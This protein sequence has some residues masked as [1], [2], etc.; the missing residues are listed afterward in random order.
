MHVA[1][2]GQSC[3]LYCSLTNSLFT[4]RDGE[5]GRW[6][7]LTSPQFLMLTREKVAYGFQIA[8]FFSP[9]FRNLQLEKA[10][11]LIECI[12]ENILFHTG[13][14][15]WLAMPPFRESLS[16]P[17][18]PQRSDSYLLCLLH[19][20]AGTLPLASPGMPLKVTGRER[21]REK[22]GGSRILFLLA[23]YGSLV[24]SGVDSTGKFETE[25]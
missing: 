5:C 9:G 24:F 20:H 10:C 1:F 6:P 8:G 18:A 25:E 13:I 19:W 11:L 3:F 17:S 2:W 4:I 23:Y 14:L 16:L 7:P 15:E 22:I 12:A 21:E